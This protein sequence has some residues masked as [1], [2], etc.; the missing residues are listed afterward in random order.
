MKIIEIN[1]LD[2]ESLQRLF[3]S[4]P[5]VFRGAVYDAPG[6]RHEPKL[7]RQEDFVALSCP[8]EPG[9]VKVQKELRKRGENAY[10]LP[11]SSS[12]SP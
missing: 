12:E 7:G 10:H 8:L 2:T 4:L 9:A 11:N 5:S 1:A 3:D 6:H